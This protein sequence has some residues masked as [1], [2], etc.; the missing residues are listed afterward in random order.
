MAAAPAFAQQAQTPRTAWFVQAG[1]SENNQSLT[2][3]A[4]RDWRWQKQYRLGL[5]TGYW[6]GAVGRWLVNG[7]GS[8]DVTQ[9]GLTPVLRLYPQA[10]RPGWFIEGGIG[11]NVIFPTYDDGKKRFSTTFQFGDHLAVGKRFG[12]QQQHEWA[13][14]FQHFSNARIERPNPGENFLQLRYSRQW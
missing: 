2:I 8:H 1:V 5:A 13:L 3:G 11:A 12:Q 6:E 14:R 9:I 4:T 7:R 10:W